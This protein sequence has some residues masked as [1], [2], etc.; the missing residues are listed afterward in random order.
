MSCINIE[1]HPEWAKCCCCKLSVSKS[2]GRLK[3]CADEDGN[4]N[5]CIK[6]MLLVTVIILPVAVLALGRVRFPV[7]D[8]KTSNGQGIEETFLRKSVPFDIDMSENQRHFLNDLHTTGCLPTAKG[9][10]SP[11]TKRRLMFGNGKFPEDEADKNNDEKKEKAEDYFF[12]TDEVLDSKNNKNPMFDILY[13]ETIDHSGDNGQTSHQI[14]NEWNRNEDNS[15]I[16]SN[17]YSENTGP[18]AHMNQCFWKSNGDK[19]SIREAQANLMKQYMDTTC[20]PCQDFYQYACGNWAKVN[21]LPKDK[22]TFDTFEILRESLDSILRD[23]LQKDAAAKDIQAHIKAKNLYKSCMDYGVLERRG[24][25]PLLDLLQALGS[26]PILTPDWNPSKFDFID[27]LANLRLY[28]NEILIAEWVGPD[29]KNSSV[30]IIQ[31]DQASLG[32]PS[33]EYFLLPANKRYLEAYKDYIFKIAILLGADSDVA[34][35]HSEEIVNFET[36]VAKITKNSDERRNVSV[37]YQKMT[38]GEL[39]SLV[40]Q[41]DWQR[42]LSIILN[43]SCNYNEPVIMLA[44]QYVKNLV[45]LL[46]KTPP[47]IISNYMLWRFVRHSVSNLDDRFKEASQHFYFTLVGREQ[48]PPRWKYCVSQVNSNMGM[49]VGSMF[50]SHYFDENSKNDTFLMAKEIHQSFQ[51]ILHTATWITNNTKDVASEKAGN[52]MLKVGY[53]DFILSQNK[54]NKKYKDVKICASLY[55]E[56][57]LNLMRHHA[58]MEHAKLHMPLNKTVWDTP[59]AVVNAYYSRNKNQIIFPAGI[60]QPPFYHRYFPRSLNYG[61]IGAVIGHEITH[62]FDDKGRLFDKFGNLHKWWTDEDIFNFHQ[63][64]QCI[65]EQ[66]SEYIIPEIGVRLDGALTQGENIADNGGIKQAYRAYQRWLSTHSGVD[67]TLPGL[68]ASGEQLFY[69]NFAQIWCGNTRPEASRNGVK[70]AV[71]S[72]GRFRVIGTLSNSEDFARVFQCPR[73]S[74]MNPESKCS[75]W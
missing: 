59:P 64:A 5:R 6:V 72:P 75:V 16:I 69:L 50:V 38:V 37:F 40:P 41:I 61:G 1:V 18:T 36:A 34:L 14:S 2:S 57:C 65:I 62:G 28:N 11:R 3:W 31:F 15:E 74:R 21:P 4:W 25:K 46:E 43:R 67:E 60:L 7:A 32:L 45:I 17:S 19:R 30:N 48:A 55:F 9:F 26:W 73:G 68:N 33:Q 20:D 58:R 12:E 71:H 22:T 42:Y 35:K 66:Y 53:P 51:E 13:D 44:L 56:N 49:A 70:T 47:R 63:R 39:G 27:L 8:N 54:L 29:I 52:M 10:Y 24:N 23:L